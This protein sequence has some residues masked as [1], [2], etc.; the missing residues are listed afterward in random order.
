MYFWN[1]SRAFFGLIK[2]PLS[3]VEKKT[4]K[5]NWIVELN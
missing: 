1:D 2:W 5:S 3:W 4:K